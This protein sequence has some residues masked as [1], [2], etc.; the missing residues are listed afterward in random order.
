MTQDSRPSPRKGGRRARKIIVIVVV[1]LGL[2]VGADFAAA[3]FAEHTVSQKARE[4]LSLSEDPA[5]TIH[6]FPFAT[7]AI[8]GDYGHITVSAD[9]VPVEDILSDVSIRA[10]LRNVTAPLSDLTSGNVDSI[11]IGD[12]EGQIT[13]KASDI[14]KVKPLDNIEDLRIDPSSESYVRN[15]E[16]TES[17]TAEGSSSEEEE[18]NK[19]STAGVRIS[20]KLQIAGEQVE[21]FAFAMIEL[22]DTTIRITPHRLQFGNDK[23]TTVVPAEVQE[24]LLPNFEADINTGDL[25]FTVTPTAIRVDPGSLTISGEAK[26]VTFAGASSSQ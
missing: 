24:R 17:D 4:Q 20:G 25:P 21:I 13:L 8:S 3:A 15:G 23:E 9:G 11:N 26:D 5:V 10:E 6:G 2:L 12:L 19:D 14:A 7:Q 1:L 18:D 22:Q 16:G